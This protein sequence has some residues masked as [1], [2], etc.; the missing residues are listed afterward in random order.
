VRKILRK[1]DNKFETENR[2]KLCS[3]A[4]LEPFEANVIQSKI[5]GTRKYDMLPLISIPVIII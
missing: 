1:D 3:T 4:G 2:Y 5:H